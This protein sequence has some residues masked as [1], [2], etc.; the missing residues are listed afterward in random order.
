MGATE[1]G[2]YLSDLEKVIQASTGEYLAGIHCSEVIFK[3]V[4]RE[5]QPGFDTGL[6]RIATPFGSGIA[7]REDACGAL[8]GGLMVIGYLFGRR[9]LDESQDL[10]WELSRKFYDRFKTN[11][12][13]TTCHS[14]KGFIP[15]W[16]EQVKCSQTVS[17]SITIL[18]Q[19]LDDAQK[20]GRIKSQR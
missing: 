15:D 11:F 14:I 17:Q 4:T 3:N 12:C 13:A 9:S 16:D 7:D 10:C 20:T 19:L 18:W 6:V 5:W 2:G 1:R 8:V